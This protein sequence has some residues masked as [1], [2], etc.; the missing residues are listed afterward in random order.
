MNIV[1]Q[2][3]AP[4]L[5]LFCCLVLPACAWAQS[6]TGSAPVLTLAMRTRVEAFKGSTVWQE[7]HIDTKIPVSQT[8]I[9]ICDMWDHHWCSGSEKRV[10]ILAPKIA[11]VVKQA[12]ALYLSLRKNP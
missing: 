10:G 4:F 7:A 3:P 8:A 5:S 12:H 2:L 6:R 1:R 11:A 9:L